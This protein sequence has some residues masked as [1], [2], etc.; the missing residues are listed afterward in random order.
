MC[1]WQVAT[2]KFGFQNKV[3]KKEQKKDTSNNLTSFSSK[4]ALK[5]ARRPSKKVVKTSIE[6]SHKIDCRLSLEEQKRQV[7]RNYY[8]QIIKSSLNHEF[9]LKLIVLD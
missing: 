9:I 1:T 5:M 2:Y 8:F 4:L 3:F 6:I 7:E